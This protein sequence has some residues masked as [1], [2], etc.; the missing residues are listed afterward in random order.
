MSVFWT[1]SSKKNFKTSEKLRLAVCAY[2]EEKNCFRQFLSHFTCVTKK[3]ITVKSDLIFA[4][5]FLPHNVVFGNLQ[6]KW[7]KTPA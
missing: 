7:Y 1:N 3:D 4:S 5:H 2:F 6:R